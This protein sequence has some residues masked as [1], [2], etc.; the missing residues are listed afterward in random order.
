MLAAGNLQWAIGSRQLA[1]SVDRW[2]LAVERGLFIVG[3][4]QL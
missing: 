4:C 1:V 3:D 2:Q